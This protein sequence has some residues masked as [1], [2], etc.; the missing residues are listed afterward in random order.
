MSALFMENVG[1]TYPSKKDDLRALDEI[2]LDIE[3]GE[4]FMVSGPSRCGKSSFMSV[5]GGLLKP[6]TGVVEIHGTNLYSLP[7]KEAAAFR[8]RH[9]GYVF[10]N[11]QLIDA[12]TVFENIAAPMHLLG[13]KDKLVQT[14]VSEV[15]DQVGM[16]KQKDEYPNKLSE[17]EKMLTAIGRS[18]VTSPRLLIYDEPTVHLDHAASV[19]ILTF[20]KELAYDHNTTI[21]TAISDVRL[22]PFAGRVAKMK[23]GRIAMVFGETQETESE[24]PFLK[25]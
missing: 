6:T 15:L 18:L 3:E 17:A 25:L 2:N 21:V 23:G 11:P 10:Q 7:E 9:L 14:R 24:P 19:K 20:L 8:L 5:V 16:T 13:I 22:H 12:F 1:L 4:L